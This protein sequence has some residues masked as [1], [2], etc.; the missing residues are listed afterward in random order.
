MKGEHMQL[1]T[2]SGWGGV[3]AELMGKRQTSQEHLERLRKQKRDLAL[4]AA[5]GNTDAQ[6]R[7]I[8]INAELAQTA[9]QGNDWDAAIQQAETRR[10][11][12]H[13]SEA[14]TA[15]AERKAKIGSH[16]ASYFGH[17]Q[18]ID[19]LLAEIAA[20]CKAAWGDLSSTQPLLTDSERPRL[21]QCFSKFGLTLAMAHFGLDAFSEIAVV[22]GFRIHRKPLSEQ[23]G[24]MVHGWL[25]QTERKEQ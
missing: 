17:V 6:K 18:R 5:L 11:E 25:Q 22:S 9:A 12:A 2:V 7:L 20:E 14:E 4:E 23:V 13:K 15:E 10:G 16:L 1:F 19:K 24:P 3:I 8:K 21:R